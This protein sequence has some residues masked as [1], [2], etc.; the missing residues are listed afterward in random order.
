MTSVF[1][2]FGYFIIF[3]GGGGST[4]HVLEKEVGIQRKILLI[5]EKLA[6]SRAL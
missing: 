1:S 2:P 4:W 6:S 3:G 5:G